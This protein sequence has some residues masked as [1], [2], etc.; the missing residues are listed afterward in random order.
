MLCIY[1]IPYTIQAETELN[2][3]L[4]LLRNQFIQDQLTTQSSILQLSNALASYDTITT[5]IEAYNKDNIYDVYKHTAAILLFYKALY[6][7][8]KSIKKEY[9]VL[10]SFSGVNPV[11]DR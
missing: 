4:A 11:I 1:V 7:P 2:T 8:N 5:Q 6:T 3:Q 9:E 10:S